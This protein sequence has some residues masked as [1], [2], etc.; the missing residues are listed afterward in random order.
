MDDFRILAINPGSTS[1][2]IAVYQNT[3]PIF[4]KNIV[5]PSEELAR[6]D[7]IAEQFQF[8]KEIIYKELQEADIQ[9]DKIQAVMGRGGLLKPI[10]S[11][12]YEVNAAM[13]RDLYEKPLKEHASN[14]GG[15]I[16]DEIARSLPNAKAYISDPVVVD[17]LCDLARVSGHPEFHR[18]SIFHALNQKSIARQHAKSIMK[19]YEDMNLI[20]VHMGGG[21]TVGAHEKGKVIDVNQGLDGEGPFS[22]ERTGTLPT[23]DLVRYCFSGKHTEKEVLKMVVGNGGLVAHLGTNSAYEAEQHALNGDAHARF[24]LEALSYQVAKAI[25]SMV[26]VLKGEVDAILLTG[27]IAHSKWITNMIIERVYR[28]APVFTYPGEDEMRAL[29]LNG[30]MVLRG[31]IDVQKYI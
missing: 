7:H 16:A 14:L 1:T 28:F 11:G 20:V 23:G 25:G 29:A 5:H 27:G 10:A 9:L 31:E 6:F 30:L 17:E 21:I 24:I 26:P 2:K 8:R 15:L 12:V 19:R 3:N 18:I 13:K 4:V 22:P